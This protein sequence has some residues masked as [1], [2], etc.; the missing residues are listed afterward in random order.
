MSS[1]LE[2]PRSCRLALTSATMLAFGL[3]A[4]AVVIPTGD[5]SGNTQASPPADDPGIDNVGRA[6]G[7][8]GVYLGRSWV[9]TADHVG[10]R[11]I[12]LLGVTYDPIPGSYVQFDHSPTEK[13]DLGVYRV[14][15]DPP[16]PS[17]EISANAPSVGEEIIAVGQGYDRLPDLFAWNANW[18][19]VAQ[20]GFYRGFKRGS[21]RNIRWGRNEIDGVDID[22]D[23]ASR[24]SRSFEMTFDE[25]GGLPDEMQVLNGDSG[26]GVFVKR[27]GEWELA[28]ILFLHVAYNGQP[29]DTAVFNNLTAAVDLSFYRDQIIQATVRQVPISSAAALCLAAL[30]LVTA[31]PLLRNR[32]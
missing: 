26:G 22:F 29:A 8:T 13:A 23:V 25:A 6:G 17:L 4:G 20:P 30:L 32:P 27:N 15:G 24:V 5:G 10:E 7:L 14:D 12:T 19:E 31:L 28:G 11:S 16:L 18:F 3:G 1:L 9:L 21:G 2:L